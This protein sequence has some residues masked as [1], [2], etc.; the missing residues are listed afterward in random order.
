M[1][2]FDRIATV[3]G[4]APGRRH[5]HERLIRYFAGDL[6]PVELR[7][8]EVE[9]L[10][11]RYRR[12]VFASEYDRRT[13][14]LG[15]DALASADPEISECFSV[16]TLEAYARRRLS[17]DD[18]ALVEAH[19]SCPVCSLQV[20]GMR[21]ELEPSAATTWRDRSDD[22][23]GRLM[24]L[25]IRPGPLVAATAAVLLLVAVERMRPQE[26]SAESNATVSMYRSVGDGLAA[27][28]LRAVD[29]DL[30]ERSLEPDPLDATVKVSADSRLRVVGENADLEFPRYV[31]LLSLDEHGSI[32]WHIP[33]WDGAIPPSMVELPAGDLSFDR[34]EPVPSLPPGR[35][36]LVLLLSHTPTN[37]ERIRAELTEDLA[38]DAVEASFV[39]VLGPRSSMT[40]WQ[41]VVP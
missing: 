13:R 21:R 16:P 41:V 30:R 9:I 25:A 29:G 20:E 34:I 7:A 23:L 15:L 26:S 3:F 5:F 38:S 6:D 18:R 40:R 22:L 11:S 17:R 31:A 36:Q 33:S 14:T 39:D 19:L 28:E 37:L 1:S 24:G 32:R 8:F 35:H 10:S 27:L 12:R 4:L 2:A